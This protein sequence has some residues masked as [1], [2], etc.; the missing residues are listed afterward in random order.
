MEWS[1]K[2]SEPSTIV[3]GTI[4][5]RRTVPILLLTSIAAVSAGW[6]T[7]E[8]AVAAGS[9][10]QHIVVI[11]QENHSFD[12]VLGAFCVAVATR[13]IKRAGL[14]D[15]C[16]GVTRAVTMPGRPSLTTMP[17]IVP[18]VD[19]TVGGQLK[20][21]DHGA[22]D[23]WP[24]L[25]GCGSGQ[26]LSLHRLNQS[27]N[28]MALAKRFAISDATFETSASPSWEG[29]VEIVAATKDGFVGNNP[30]YLSGSGVPHE[31]WGWGCDSNKQVQWGSARAWMPSCIPDFSLPANVYPYG[32]AFGPTSVKHVP[33]IMDRLAAAGLTWKLYAGNGPITSTRPKPDGYHWA[34]CPYFAGCL[35]TGQSKSFVPNSRIIT[36]AVQGTL[37]NFAVVTPTA[38]QSQHNSESW[39]AGD[40]WMGKVVSALEDGPQWGSTAIFITWDDCGCFYDHVN[41]LQY[42]PTWGIR[43]PTVIVSPYA[44]AGFTDTTPTSYSGF[45]AY[46]EHTFGLASLNTSDANAYDFRN[47]FNY[48]Q[49]PIEGP[50]MIFRPVPA[51]SVRWLEDHPSVDADDPT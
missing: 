15:R 32:G 26:C 4:A 13:T 25:T 34:T 20:A 36:D 30:K 46:V 3:R 40:D 29:H 9:P 6:G 11:Y 50:T 27:L 51:P 28:L 35:Y 47:S 38:R 1:H 18:W 41:P 22:M 17:D 33:T 48:A 21:I 5:L 49:V 19:H 24:K 44:K 37:P 10:I 16:N 45:L 42:D 8:Q 23:G 31:G 43:V 7:R 2:R 14:N 12:D 39:I